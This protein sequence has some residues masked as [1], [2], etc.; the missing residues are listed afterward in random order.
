VDLD[1]QPGEVQ[2][3]TAAEKLRGRSIAGG[4]GR[5]FGIAEVQSQPL[6]DQGVRPFRRQ[7][8]A[9]LV[10]QP[11]GIGRA[12]LAGGAGQVQGDALMPQDR[13][14]GAAGVVQG[15]RRAADVVEVAVE[16]RRQGGGGVGPHLGQGRAHLLRALAGVD[17][18]Q[19][20]RPLDEGLV[21]EAIAHQAPDPG[22]RGVE[23]PLKPL[24]VGDVPTMRLLSQGACPDLGGIGVETAHGGPFLNCLDASL[25]Q[26]GDQG[27]KGG[28][29][30][31]R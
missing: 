3:L 21:G 13:Q 15:R 8:Q 17:G 16:H 28:R 30:L 22:P 11:P 14:V 4:E 5:V 20:L 1:S 24:G 10:D 12:D 27:D 25:A 18:D 31:G 26:I 23:P 19:A 7:A 29:P 9:E 2:P 6:V